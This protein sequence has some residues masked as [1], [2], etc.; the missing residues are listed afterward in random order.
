[1]LPPQLSLVTGKQRVFAATLRALGQ[2]SRPTAAMP[3]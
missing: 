3:R 2:T 1:M